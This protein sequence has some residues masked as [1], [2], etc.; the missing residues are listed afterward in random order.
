MSIKVKVVQLGKGVLVSELDAETTVHDALAAQGI[1][2]DGMEIRVNSEATP[3]HYALQDGDLVTV[4]PMI[5]GGLCT[6]DF[7]PRGR[8]HDAGG[9]CLVVR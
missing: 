5:K 1:P 2:T 4:V 8:H 7:G 9:F 6:A 3:P